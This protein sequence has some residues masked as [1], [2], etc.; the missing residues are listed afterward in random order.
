MASRVS[1]ETV[2]PRRSASWRS[3]ASSSSE[4]FTVVRFMYASI[5]P[6]ASDNRVGPQTNEPHRVAR[7]HA[8]SR[9]KLP[10]QRM[11]NFSLVLV[12]VVRQSGGGSA[13][14][15]THG[16]STDALRPRTPTSGS[17]AGLVDIPCVGR[18][19][20]KGWM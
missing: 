4:S 3:R 15:L 10:I 19:P 11:G 7:D 12:I 13:S 8:M 6:P 9:Q 16:F 18:C 2:T 20:A 5:P 1:S 14:P 17:A